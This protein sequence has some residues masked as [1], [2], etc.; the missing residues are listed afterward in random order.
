MTTA[1]K[2]CGEPVTHQHMPEKALDT[3]FTC[4][5]WE[6][7]L[8]IADNPNTVRV[9]GVHYFI[10]PDTED[11]R[12]SGFGGSRFIIKFNDGREVTTRNLWCQGGIP[13]RFRT[14]LPDNAT[15]IEG[16]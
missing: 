1:C 12:F 2:T 3:C 5:F 8:S 6:E 9:K 11:G 4:W 16:A 14:L 10:H 15:F 13:K 7:K